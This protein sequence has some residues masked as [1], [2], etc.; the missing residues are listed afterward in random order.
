[1]V[2]ANVAELKANLSRYL[3]IVGE[4][5]EVVICERNRPIA[6]I[7]R[8]AEYDAAPREKAAAAGLLEVREGACQPLR[9]VRVVCS[10]KG[11]DVV[12][13]ERGDR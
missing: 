1:M 9:G 11:V 6:R 7:V 3:R 13:A 2:R 10:G 4:G 8:L 5:E 12:A